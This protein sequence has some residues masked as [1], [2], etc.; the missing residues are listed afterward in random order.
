MRISNGFVLESYRSLFAF[1]IL[2]KRLMRPYFSPY[3]PTVE[4]F[5]GSGGTNIPSRA[6]CH[7]LRVRECLTPSPWGNSFCLTI[8]HQQTHD[9]KTRTALQTLSIKASRTD[10]GT[11]VSNVFYLFWRQDLQFWRISEP[12]CCSLFGN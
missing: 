12:S 9:K 11:G 7:Q 3:S 6:G 2:H 10:N 1:W 8:V 5:P 4:G